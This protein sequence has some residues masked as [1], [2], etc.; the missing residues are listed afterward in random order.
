M[1]EYQ[2]GEAVTVTLTGGGLGGWL[3][4]LLYDHHNIEL[5]R[6]TGPTGT[7]DDGLGN[8]V[9]YPVS[10]QATAPMEAGDYVWEAAWYGGNS[11]GTGHLEVR[12]PVTI[13]V[14]TSTAVAEGVFPTTWGRIKATF[15]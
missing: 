14:V 10:L 13:R 5:D 7:G 9:T 6:A 1:T 3:R 4:G 12:A 15:E 11:S 2:P 8:P